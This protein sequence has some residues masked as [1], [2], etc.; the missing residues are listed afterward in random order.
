[1][2]PTLVRRAAIALLVLVAVWLVWPPPVDEAL[3]RAEANG[4]RAARRAAVHRNLAA[5]AL[6]RRDSAIRAT[7]TSLRRLRA[8]L[9]APTVLPPTDTVWLDSLPRPVVGEVTPTDTLIAIR[10]V[11][12][13]WNAFVDTLNADLATLEAA[14]T[15][16]RGRSSLVIQHLQAALAAQDTVVAAL[17]AQVQQ[18]RRPWYRRVRGGVE[19]WVAGMACGSAGYVLAGP[20]GGLGAGLVCAGLAG[21]VR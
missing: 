20:V 10:L 7:D 18:A 6:A 16:E 5:V 21:V 13:R 17:R 11:R 15:L 14:V 1:M 4:Y 8:R 2:T 9:A 19:H 12:L 3:A